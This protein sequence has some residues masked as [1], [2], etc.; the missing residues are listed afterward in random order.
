GAAEGQGEF[1]FV[2]EAVGEHL[3]LG[4]DNMDLALA[5]AVE[6][7]L[8]GA[9]RLDAV[10]YGMLTQACRLAKE[11]LLGDKPPESYSVTVIGRGRQVVGGTQHANLTAQDVRR[12]VFEGFLPLARYEAEPTQGAR[13]GLH[14]MGLPY[15]SDPAISHHLAEFLHR[16]CGEANGDHASAGHIPHAILF[17][18]GVFQ[19]AALR[20]RLVDILQHWFDK[21]DRP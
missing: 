5:K 7:R 20:Q 15:V 8:P 17:N 19:P 14:E 16:H 12:I 13:T 11:T 4:G 6:G 18:G 10:Q 9:G 2:R 1:S 3:L 21:P